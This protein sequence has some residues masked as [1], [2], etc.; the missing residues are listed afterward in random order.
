MEEV[1]VRPVIQ[2]ERGEKDATGET[3]KK[4][5]EDG[6]AQLLVKGRSA[7]FASALP[8]AKLEIFDGLNSWNTK[9]VCDW[10]V[11]LKWGLSTQKVEEYVAIFTQNDIDGQVRGTLLSVTNYQ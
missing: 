7:S 6:E 2:R 1:K 8:P 5:R 4:G 10:F 9:R 3:S 11:G